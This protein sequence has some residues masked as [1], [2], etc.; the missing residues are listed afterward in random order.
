V[1]ILLGN[2]DPACATTCLGGHIITRLIVDRVGRLHVGEYGGHS[3][4]DNTEKSLKD[5]N[6]EHMM[7]SL[8]L[9]QKSKSM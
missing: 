4:Y 7:T 1:G 6:Q 5:T 3:V 2:K 9:W 8:L